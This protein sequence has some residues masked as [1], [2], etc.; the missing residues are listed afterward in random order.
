MP[1]G[2][3]KSTSSIRLK[4]TPVTGLKN[5][6]SIWRKFRPIIGSK[7]I[8][9]I[10]FCLLFNDFTVTSKKIIKSICRRQGDLLTLKIV[11]K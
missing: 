8:R 2:V 6:P 11:P 4:F 10:L 9:T 1:T 3:R 5:T 7:I